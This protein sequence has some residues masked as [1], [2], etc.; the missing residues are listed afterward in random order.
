MNLELK[1]YLLALAGNKYYVG[2]SDDPEFRVL[3]H[4]GSRASKWTRRY[5]PLRIAKIQRLTVE[6]VN[7][8][9]LYENWMTLQA[10]ERFGWENVR[11]GGF[12]VG[13]NYLLRERVA[14]IYGFAQ[15]KIGYLLQITAASFLA[16]LRVG[17]FMF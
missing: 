14:Y 13:G 12:F 6:S 1:L 3:E 8:A 9:M 2:Q 11:G 17:L 7:E 5:K 4:F 15:N 16:D 10:M